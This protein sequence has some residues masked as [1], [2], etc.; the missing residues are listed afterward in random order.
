MA[1]EFILGTP[2]LRPGSYAV[3]IYLCSFGVL[4]KCTHACVIEIGPALPYPG[5]VG[6]E[7]IENGIVFGDFQY[8][9]IRCAPMMESTV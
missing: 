7:A 1:V 5:I 9:D 2:L 6:A 3:N 4:D 8:S